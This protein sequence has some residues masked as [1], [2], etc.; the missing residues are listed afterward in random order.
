MNSFIAFMCFFFFTGAIQSQL[1]QQVRVKNTIPVFTG[2][3]VPANKPVTQSVT[4]TNKSK[5]VI[6]ALATSN[7]YTKTRLKLPFATEEKDYLVQKLGHFFILN[8]DII[9]DNDF[10]KTLSFST[11]P[12]T[13]FLDHQWANG[14]IPIAVDPSIYE[15]GL[16]SVVHDAIAAFNNR[17]ELCLVPRTNQDDYVNIIYS[18]ALGS[19]AGIS[20]IGRQGGGQTLFLANS[21]N[22]GTVM[23]EMMHAA[24]F[25]HEQCRTDRDQ[26]VKIVEENIE[27]GRKNQFQFEPGFVQSTYDYCSIMHYT[28]TAFSKNGK[29][30]IICALSGLVV[31]CPACIGNRTDF[32]EKDIKGIDN[33]YSK[34]SR[35]PCKTPFPNP[36]PQMQ[37][38]NSFPKAES[39]EAMATFRN[40]AN[41]IATS[42]SNMAGAFPNFYERRQGNNLMGGTVFL[43]FSTAKWEDIPL[44]ALGNPPLDDFAARMRA[45]QNYA[46]QNGYIGGFPTYHHV[47]KGQG[48]VCGTVLI[49]R[50]GADWRDVPIGELGNPPLDNIKAR[51][52]SADDYALNHGYIGGFPTFHHTDYGNGIVCGIILIKKEYGEF[53]NVI[54]VEGPR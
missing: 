6:Q 22:Y 27:D 43:K 42:M 41:L 1:P 45:T 13:P 21:A 39:Q 32:S 17:T 38:A 47:D 16:G 49:T 3:E 29:P 2:K 48:I 53:K 51:M 19:A 23:H 54:V 31:P 34:I 33:F 24:G 12:N 20:S 35:F 52:T 40:R 9:V 18:S 46:V 11:L 4:E 50:N 36:H 5:A 7:L 37:F 44:S 25:Y 15:N 14:T 10:P 30:T 8:G 28:E 26:F